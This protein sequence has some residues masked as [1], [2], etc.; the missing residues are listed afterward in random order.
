MHSKSQL[1]K[2]CIAALGVVFGDIGTSP[3]YTMKE[4][5]APSH[6]ILPSTENILGILS[7]VFWSLSLVVLFKYIFFI[8]R[9]D[10][11]GEG[12]I[13]SLLALVGYK[14]RGSLT[15]KLMTIG[16]VGAALLYADGMITPAISVLSAVEGLAVATPAFHPY[17]V[18][19]TCFILVLLF[20]P[21]KH[22]THRV[23]SV[24][25]YVMILWF[26]TLAVTGGAWVIQAPQVLKAVNPYY[27]I[28]FFINNGMR[29][30]FILSSVVLCITG[31]E[32][33]Y[34]DMGHFGR[35]PIRYAWIYL[36][37]P[38]LILNYFGQGSLFMI[39]GEEVIH[40]PFY[41]LVGGWFLYPLIGIATLATVIASQA[42]ISGAYSI[43]HQAIQLGYLP[44]MTV[45]HTSRE[46][47][48]QIYV[49]KVNF[50][51]MVACIS[52]VLL[53]KDSSNLAAAYGIAVTGTMGITSILFYHYVRRYMGWSRLKAGLVLGTFLIVDLTFFSATLTKFMHGGWVPAVVALAIF[54]IMTTWKSGRRLLAKYMLSV[55]E[56]LNEFIE[57]VKQK[58]VPRVKGTAFFLTPNLNVAPPT[59][60]HHLKHNQVLHERVALLSI[61]TE[62]VPDIPPSER[63]RSTELDIGFFQIIVRYGYM[64]EPNIPEILICCSS[65]GFQTKIDEVSFYIGKDTLLTTGTGKMSLWRKS[66]FAFLSRNARPATMYYE[67]PSDRVI[68]LGSQ[69]EV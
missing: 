17:V 14:G 19:L 64:Q 4:T 3:L 27:A 51:L 22:G 54:L 9:A 53:F 13:L 66:L 23:G 29:A 39:R 25:G 18:P 68:E 60:I 21:Q 48:G 31:A 47:E 37:Y 56:P 52:L 7:L 12:G 41:S 61:V 30:F 33:L 42:L 40:N 65:T 46:T 57:E 2:L 6:G 55:S 28:Q 59:L 50:A 5:F 34:A 32:A 11:N 45:V 63:V 26:L 8:M 44:R 35:K 69:I 15:T 43:T 62:H 38:A 10:N 1:K 58:K 20:L 24:F 36:V 67:I 16:L 49:P